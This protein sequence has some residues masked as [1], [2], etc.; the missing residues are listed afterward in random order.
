MLVIKEDERSDSKTVFKEL[1]LIETNL[2][3]I[4]LQK[5]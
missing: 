4:R 2:D 5:N 1:V 3:E